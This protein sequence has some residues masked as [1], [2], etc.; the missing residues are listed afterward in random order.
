MIAFQIKCSLFSDLMW[1]ATHILPW[2]LE[3]GPP[4]IFGFQLF[5]VSK[6]S[7]IKSQIIFQARPLPTTIGS[8]MPSALG[9]VF[10]CFLFPN[11]R[12]PSLKSRPLPT[13]RPRLLGADPL[14]QQSVFLTSFPT[15]FIIVWT[16]PDKIL[17]ICQFGWKT[18]D[19]KWKGDPL[20]LLPTIIALQVG[21]TPPIQNNNLY[22]WWEKGPCFATEIPVFVMLSLL[23]HPLIVRFFS[24][25]WY[26]DLLPAVQ[27]DRGL[28]SL[29]HQLNHD[30]LWLSCSPADNP[31]T[32][33]FS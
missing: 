25:C 4:Y 21:N 11:C 16:N 32:A 14:Q 28:T 6:L 17:E 19:I 13:R 7:K 2:L 10:N 24:S 33:A 3:A 12:K 8:D 29:R 9:L 23:S 22:A 31:N 27:W 5:S 15:F 30:N 26:W 1:F 18:F 20:S